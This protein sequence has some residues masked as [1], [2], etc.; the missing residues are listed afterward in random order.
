MTDDPATAPESAETPAPAVAGDVSPDGARLVALCPALRSA[1]LEVGYT[2]DGLEAALG[3]A[4][5]AALD[6]SDA[7]ALRRAAREAGAV[8]SLLRLFV[9]GDPLPRTEIGAALPGVD[10]D[11]ALDAG[12][13]SAGGPTTDA[14]AGPGHHPDVLRAVP[15]LRPLDLGAGTRWVFSDTDGSMVRVPT[16]PDHV[17]GVGQASLSLLRV[18]PDSEAASILDLGTGCGVQLLHALDHGESAVGTDVTG[19]C[20]DFTAATLA[21]NGLSAEL[22]RG[23]WFEPVA[24]RRFDRIVSNPPFVVGTPEVGHSYRESGLD[25]DGASRTVVSGAPAHLS[26]GGT[27]VVL[28]SWVEVEGEDWRSRVASW[29]PDEGIDA[30]VLRRDTSDPDLYVWTWLTDE[31][32]DPRDPAFADAA[33]AWAAHLAS[34]GVTGIGFGYVYLRAI[35]G[36]GSVLCED[37]THPFDD[38]L[39]DEAEAYFARL[40]WLRDAAGRAG[41]EDVALDAAVLGLA[42]DVLVHD[43]HH[44]VGPDDAAAPHS[45]VVERTTGA[46]WRHPV[47][48]PTLALLRGI[49][50]GAL[51]LADLVAL[52]AFSLGLDPDDLAG[53]A[54]VVVAD[55]LRHGVVVP[56]GVDGVVPSRA[57]AAAGSEATA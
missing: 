9:L 3:Q 48:E 47:D 7:P 51:P 45:Y 18:T 22:L 34:A 21:V 32:M 35:D 53:P 40:A 42:P 30:W 12:L 19:R 25:L 6:R 37:L 5:L 13:L 39:G 16:R 55:L 38:G 28:A 29:I 26:L 23:P 14:G 17:L 49:A 15:D 50:G 41:G 33:D 27:A 8:G 44:P 54:R 2:V 10:L 36:P 4:G 52:A 20:L 1:F 46:R 31:G 57:A 24:G 11:A 56:S 43:S